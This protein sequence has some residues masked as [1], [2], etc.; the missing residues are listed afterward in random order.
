MVTNL[1]QRSIFPIE[2][3]TLPNKDV[4]TVKMNYSSVKDIP[5]PKPN[6]K[7]QR[8]MDKED[9]FL[10]YSTQPRKPK[11]RECHVEEFRSGEQEG[12]IKRKRILM[13]N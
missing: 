12:N 7:T 2:L 9:P 10:H 6:F 13:K 1:L 4:K 11:C 3:A 5:K 8:V